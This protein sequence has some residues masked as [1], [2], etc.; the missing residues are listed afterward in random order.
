VGETDESP[1]PQLADAKMS[2]LAEALTPDPPKS[3]TETHRP[4]LSP[5]HLLPKN[6]HNWYVILSRPGDFRPS[7][8]KSQRGGIPHADGARWARGAGLTL[9][10]RGACAWC[11]L[12]GS[13]VLVRASTERAC[14]APAVDKCHSQVHHSPV[15]LQFRYDGPYLETLTPW[16]RYRCLS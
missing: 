7:Y 12:V 8:R 15:P 13:S 5:A 3:D 9:S 16:W 10:V 2:V 14:R 1:D 4:S 11:S 6:S